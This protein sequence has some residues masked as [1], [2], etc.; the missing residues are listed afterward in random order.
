VSRFGV[1]ALPTDVIISHDGKVLAKD[2]GSPGLSGYVS[3][4]RQHMRPAAAP[5]DSAPAVAQT[6]PAPATPVPVIPAEGTRSGTRCSGRCG[7]GTCCP[8]STGNPGSNGKDRR[9]TAAC[10]TGCNCSQRTC[11]CA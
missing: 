11:R 9:K 5:A 7:S 8:T 10:S 2:V 1:T 3:R 6:Q 4:L